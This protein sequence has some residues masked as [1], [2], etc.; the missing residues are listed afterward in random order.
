MSGWLGSNEFKGLHPQL[1]A[2]MKQAQDELDWVENAS[3][4]DLVTL[5]ASQL[6]FDQAT[7]DAAPSDMSAFDFGN[8]PHRVLADVFTPLFPTGTS[9]ADDLADQV[10][11]CRAFNDPPQ[12]LDLLTQHVV[13]AA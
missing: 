1:L 6:R 10:Q 13:N 5:A 11:L 3:A 8:L 7:A 4:R 9:L 2:R 12:V